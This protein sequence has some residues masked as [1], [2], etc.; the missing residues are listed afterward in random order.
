MQIWSIRRTSTGRRV[1]K[2]EKYGIPPDETA[3]WLKLFQEN[4]PKVYFTIATKHPE[5]KR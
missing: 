2:L 1:W 4:E 5:V 3:H